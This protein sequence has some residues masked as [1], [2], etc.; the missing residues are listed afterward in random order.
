MT[1]NEFLRRFQ[2]KPLLQ[3]QHKYQHPSA[4]R[5]AAVLIPLFESKGKLQVVLTKRAMHLKHHAGQISFPGGK[6]EPEDETIIDT[7]LR[8]A[9]EEIGLSPEY[10]S[11]IG[12]MPVYQT[13]TGFSVIPVVAVIPDYISFSIDENEVAEIFNVPL[14]HFLD[15]DNQHS[16]EVQHKGRSHHV[17]FMPYKNYHIWG[18][19]AS[20]LKDLA[21]HLN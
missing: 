19:T 13:I 10:V 20:M 16:I 15:T 2:L 17:N 12:Q 6:V 14:R 18:A 5:N 4:T 9:E 3:S 8:E 7:A 11:I 1:K 21:I